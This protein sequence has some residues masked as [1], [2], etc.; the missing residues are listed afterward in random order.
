MQS[1][2]AFIEWSPVY[3]QDTH[4]MQF[5]EE[6]GVSQPP[7]LIDVQTDGQSAWQMDIAEMLLHFR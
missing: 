3:Y 7:D 6:Y 2:S 5:I 1:Q 4:T